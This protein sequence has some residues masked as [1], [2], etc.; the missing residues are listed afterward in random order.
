M[1][2]VAA[3]VVDTTKEE[4]QTSYDPET[5]TDEEYIM[6]YGMPRR[7]GRYPWGSGKD[8]YQNSRDFLGRVD[9]MRKSGFTYTDEDGKTWTG[10]NAIAKSLGYS[11]SDFRTV[12]A[13]AK[14]QRRMDQVATAKRLRD[15]EGMNPSE[16]GR[17]MGINES[18]VRSLLDENSASR[19][20]EARNTAEYLKKQLEDQEYGMLDVGV[21]VNKQL[22]VSKEKFDQALFMLQAEEG[23]HI[24]NGGVPQV[25][26]KGQQTTQKVL[27][28]PDVEYKQI[29][30]YDKVGS[31]GNDVTH[32]GGEHYDPKFHYPSS[33]DSGRL[34]IRYDE[35]G[36]TMKD[37]LMEIRPGVKD[38]N[39]GNDRY[40][41]CRIMVDDKYYLK[42][43]AIYGQP[44]D[45]PDGVD[46]I[47]NTNKSNKKEIGEVLKKIKDDPDDPFGA[48]LKDG[49][50]SWYD[51]ENGQRQLN[52]V[53]KTRGEG[54]WNKWK[55]TLP[56][57][58][59]AKQS[60]D[61]AKR[62]LDISVAESK[63]ELDDIMALTNPTVKKHYLDKY[64]EGADTKAY[65]LKAAALPGQK[66]HVMLPVNSLKDNEVYAP[67]YAD[68][69]KLALVRFPHGNIS[70]IPILTVNNKNKE[71][72]QMIGKTPIDAI[73]INHKNADRMSGADFDGDF[74]LTIPTHD[75]Q[76]KVRIQN[77]DQLPGLIGFDT[78]HAYGGAEMKKDAKGNEHWY[79]NGKEFT[80][81]KKTDLEMGRISNLLTDMTLAGAEPSEVERALRHSMVVIDAEKH[82]LDYKQSERDNNIAGLRRKYQ[83]HVDANGNIR[84]GGASTLLSRA[85]AKIDVPKRQGTPKVNLKDKAWYDPTRP[86]GA[87]IYT[88]ARDNDYIDKNG[89]ARVRTQKARQMNEHDDARELL[90]PYKHPMEVIYADYANQMKSLARQARIESSKAGKI[91]Y[92]KEAK[93]KYAA[94]VASL[95]EKLRIA[96]MNAP[97]ERAANRKANAVVQRK[98]DDA[99]AA[100]IELKAKDIKKMNQKALTKARTDMGSSSRRD[101]NIKVTD[102]EWEA[103]QAGAISETTLRKILSNCDPDTLR[104]KAMPKQ[105]K[106]IPNSTI[107]RMK[108]MSGSYTIQ[109]IADKFGLST[110]TV[111]KYLKGEL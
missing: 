30:D 74:A 7:S 27:A 96:E 20:K 47:F 59:L 1:S 8:P 55:D 89:K 48:L 34:K 18:S 32:D 49:G 44:K 67:G 31:V 63:A 79:R 101:R 50:Q 61:L 46:I 42:G 86:E 24:Y 62:Q 51:D 78:K 88:T 56:S 29:Y 107:S 100:G 37:G 85:S 82:H 110:S 91:A 21:G 13:I 22:N 81:M 75:R 84:Y 90:S 93:A 98:K 23:Y 17:K 11:S 68:G 16:I 97:K 87:L 58:F 77:A 95:S 69:T 19:M 65:E 76:G 60:K 72:I 15:K 39:L 108:A 105:T 92:S 104:A 103:I 26:N 28:K 4:I 45:F 71:G 33:L 99:E 83:A 36:G 94:E 14:D 52:K 10:D 40:A 5:M 25:T 109:Q 80:H 64:A 6:H 57:Q 12:Y 73:G 102:K 9:Q 70:E 66:Y 35:D 2:K 43:M 106:Q 111:A 41:Q 54:D 3:S 38:L 53:N